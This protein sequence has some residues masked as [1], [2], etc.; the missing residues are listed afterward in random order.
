MS[1]TDGLTPKTDSP[2]LN[3]NNAPIDTPTTSKIFKKPKVI[4]PKTAQSY[5]LYL[6][7]EKL[8]VASKEN[9]VPINQIVIQGIEL[10]L[11]Q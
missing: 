3:A 4:K 1:V 7:I 2:L 11:K 6:P 9:E 8:R 5:T 10:L